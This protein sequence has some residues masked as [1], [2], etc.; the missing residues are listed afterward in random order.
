MKRPILLTLFFLATFLQAGP[1]GLTFVLP[2]LFA[3]FNGSEADVGNTLALTAI[4][5]LIIVMLSGHVTERLGRMPTIA[6]SGGII[7][8][9]ILLFATASHV[10]G[11]VYMAGVL[12]GVGWGLFYTLTPVALGQII[13]PEERVRYFTLLSV[14]IMAGFGL[15]P[16]MSSGLATIG[17]GLPFAFL[18]TAGLC[19]VSA[20]IF[21]LIT[22]AF[23]REV[24]TPDAAGHSAKLSVAIAAKIMRTR[25][26]VPI[27]MVGIGASV[28]AGVTNFQAVFA[29]QSGFEYADY[30]VAY[31]VTVIACRVLFAEFVGGRTPYAVISVL[32][33]VMACSVGLFLVLGGNWPL[34]ILAAVLFGIGYGVSYPIIKAMA[35]NEAEADLLPQTMQLFGLSYF[36]GVFGF[37]FAA[38]WIIVKASIV[39]LLM[40]ALG[41][42]LL[43]TAMSVRRLFDR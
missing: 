1:Y 38:G 30:F 26:A 32:M 33:V 17:L 23:H 25:A 8:L 20:L 15:A 11:Q 43:E 9:S 18:V 24:I 7:S 35:A 39:V 21:G 36:I 14:F 28:F 2:P 27:W 12:L 13:A 16:V 34:F 3:G 4:S 6:W 37:P 19:G 29:I 41:L 40:V 31:T 5:T 42:A 22:P 10:G